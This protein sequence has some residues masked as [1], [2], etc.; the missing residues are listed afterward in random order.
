MNL[1][2]LGPPGAGKGTQAKRLEQTHGLVQLAT[3]DMLRA[4]VASGSALGTRVKAIMDAGRLVPDDI[5]IAMLATRIAEPDAANGFILDGFPRTVPQAEALD[6]MLEAASRQ[7][8]PRDP[9]GGRRAGADRADCRAFLLPHM[10]RQLSRA[11]SPPADRRA[12]A[13]FA[14]APIWCIAPTT[15]PRRSRQGS[16]PIAIRPHRYYLIT[17]SAAFC[18]RWTAWPTS[19]R[20]QGRS[21]PYC[22]PGAPERRSAGVMVDASARP[23][24]IAGLA[25]G[26]AVLPGNLKEM[27]RW[28]ELLGSIS[29]TRSGCRSP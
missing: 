16:P 14:A 1:I 25:G 15:A 4:A 23:H 3:G 18:A 13:T 29:R 5:I 17:A 26:V 22:G 2:L 12:S 7:P 8:R 10:R 21:K 9:D 11:P 6:R 19:T 20:L 24:I 27:R 28:R